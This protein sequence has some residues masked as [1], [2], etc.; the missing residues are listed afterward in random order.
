M[1]ITIIY[2]RHKQHIK[3]IAEEMLSKLI[4]PF[5]IEKVTKDCDLIVVMGGDGTYLRAVP[6]A[7]KYRLP[8]LAV[9]LGRVSFLAESI[10]DLNLAIKNFYAGKYLLDKRMVLDVILKRGRKTK[11]LGSILNDAVV[12]KQGIS[13]LFNSNIHY[14]KKT[15][16]YRADGVIVATP[17]GATADNLSAGGTIVDPNTKKYL[18]TPVCPHVRNWESLLIDEKLSID[19]DF[20]SGDRLAV[21]LDGSKYL[22]LRKRDTLKIQKSLQTVDFIR[23]KKY[24]FNKILKEKIR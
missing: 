13:R 7:L 8:V 17:T 4:I 22:K 5:V 9:G 11:L 14:G 18:V 19:L 10:S 6:L 20:E 15:I 24:N 1:S 21:T 16:S 3:D 2:N 12:S 23:F